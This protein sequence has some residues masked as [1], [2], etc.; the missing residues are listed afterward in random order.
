MRE[1]EITADELRPHVGFKEGAYARHRVYLCEHAELLVLC[2]RPGQR[3]PIHDHNGSFG[4]PSNSDFGQITLFPHEAVNCYQ[5]NAAPDGTAPANLQQL[6]RSCG[7][8]TTASNTGGALL[9]QVLCDTHLGRCPAGARYPKPT[10]VVLQA[11]P[12]DLA[13]MPDPCAG[14]PRTDWCPAGSSGDGS[15]PTGP[16]AGAAGWWGYVRSGRL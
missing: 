3:T 15:A 14:V 16:A 1:V 12:T 13:S 2:W 6:Q 9:S 4:N 8:T 10:G 7:S 5:G 11:L